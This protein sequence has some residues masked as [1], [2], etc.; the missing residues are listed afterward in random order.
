MARCTYTICDH[1]LLND[2]P[3]G[4]GTGN[5]SSITLML[6]A[7]EHSIEEDV[8]LCVDCQKELH[9]AIMRWIRPR[10]TRRS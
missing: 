9:G 5:V 1:C 4:V 6:K 2:T 3:A 7:G 8:D 10:E